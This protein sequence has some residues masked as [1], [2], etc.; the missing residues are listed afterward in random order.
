M[1]FYAIEIEE[2]PGFGFQGGPEFSTNVQTLASGSEKR[3]ADWAVCRHR[4]T[5]PFNNITDEAYLAIKAVF[6]I[7]RG[8]THTFLYKDWGDYQAF[9]EQF[10]TGDGST[11]TFQ[12]KKIS[13]LQ[14][15][16]ATYERLITKPSGT[17][18]IKSNGSVVTPSIDIY[19][20]L[21]TFASAPA[22]GA[23]L[24]WSGEFR[25]QVRFDIDSLPFSLASIFRAGGFAQNGSIDLLEVLNENDS[26]T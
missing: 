23:A 25:V 22:D 7:C 4:Y 13:S 12:L 10:G 2:C 14:G 8:K 16:S 11:K 26:A 21:V 19:S 18:T 5:A 20:G 24:T 15:T 17:I 6:L 9:D 3:N 1:A